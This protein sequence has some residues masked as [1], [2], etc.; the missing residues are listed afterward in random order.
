MLILQEPIPYYKFVDLI[1]RYAEQEGA[2]EFLKTVPD[3]LESKNLNNCNLIVAMETEHEHTI[4]RQA[5]D[6]VD[7]VVV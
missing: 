4:L 5:P 6:C 2:R 1:K 3:S 7:N